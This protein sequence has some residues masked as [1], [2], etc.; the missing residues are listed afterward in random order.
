MKN[1]RK[2]GRLFDNDTESNSTNMYYEM[3]MCRY[4]GGLH[5]VPKSTSIPNTAFDVGHTIFQVRKCRSV[6]KMML[7][8][9]HM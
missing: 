5:G 8:L 1:R 7:R 9:P 4:L 2:A 3:I 6:H